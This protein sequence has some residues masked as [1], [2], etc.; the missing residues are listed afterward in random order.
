MEPIK[1]KYVRE[2]SL[3]IS[4]DWTVDVEE[5]DD[6]VSISLKPKPNEKYPA[7]PHAKLV[8][9]KL[10]VK[11]GLIYLPGLQEQSYE[12]SDM[13]VHWRQRRYFY[14]M[15]GINFSGCVVTYDIHRESLYAWIPALNVGS[16]V[17]FN[18]QVPSIKEVKAEYDFDDVRYIS[19]LGD[20]LTNFVHYNPRDKIY[21]LHHYQAPKN[22][23]REAIL[24]DGRRSYLRDFPFEFTKLKPAMNAARVIKDD[25]EIKMIRRANAISAQAHTNVLKGIAH[26]D[27]EAEIEAI[28]M[29]TCV[30]DQA[31]EQS[32]GIIAGSGSNA[33]VLHYIANN[34][35]LKGRQLV[36]LDA[37]AE[38]KCYASDVTRT[39]P[40]SGN[41]TKE[42]KDIYDLVAKMQESSIAMIKPGVDF[43]IIVENSVK[44]AVEG[45]IKLGLLQNGTSEELYLSGAWR[46]FFP[47]G[48]GHHV[49]LEVHDVG[50]GSDRLNLLSGHRSANTWMAAY[51]KKSLDSVISAGTTL[52]SH[53][54]VTI[55]PG[56]YFSRYALED[57][58]LKDTRYAKF[59]NKDLL[60]KYYPVGGVR[61]EDDILVTEDGYE[62]LTT[63]PKGDDALKIINEWK[64]TA[65]GVA[66]R[67]GWLW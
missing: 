44:V 54:V 47:H 53:M 28:F 51:S 48:L 63:A 24:I 26:F 6:I 20:Y 67:R 8:A 42:A 41:F 14:Y 66:K 30:S 37:G 35:P 29:A 43:G 46:A 22:V 1:G 10:G 59:I 33:S 52:L 18:G 58:F 5:F 13:P 15:S 65:T 25:Y 36:C 31:K 62:N 56:I 4:S 57:L 39:F 2:R 61:I 55:E 40:I 60:A 16:G 23:A 7:K 17:I 12:D 21:Q 38:W 9:Q 27:N 49:G 45:L 64:E 3:S 11:S 50:D 34:E 19:T 32:Y